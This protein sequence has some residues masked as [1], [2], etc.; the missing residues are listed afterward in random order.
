MPNRR[1]L[2]HPQ[3]SEVHGIE[4]NDNEIRA[5]P[6]KHWHITL[7]WQSNEESKMEAEVRGNWSPKKTKSPRIIS[8]IRNVSFINNKFIKK[9]IHLI[10]SFQEFD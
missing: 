4:V 8:K 5:C 6:T 10:L 1:Y 7:L 2:S 9:L 3:M